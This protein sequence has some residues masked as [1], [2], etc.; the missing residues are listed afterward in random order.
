MGHNDVTQQ[1]ARNG[2]HYYMVF[3]ESATPKLHRQY[4]GMCH[5]VLGVIS[6]ERAADFCSA[7]LQVDQSPHKMQLAPLIM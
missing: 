7:R 2:L 4:L 6:L 1:V 5:R 3:T